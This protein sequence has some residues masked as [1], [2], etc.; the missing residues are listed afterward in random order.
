MAETL[1]AFLANR[2]AKQPEYIATEALGYL[3]RSSSECRAALGVV[4]QLAV[5]TL[6]NEIRYRTQDGEG[7]SGR[8]DVI[9]Q[10]GSGAAVIVVEAKFWAGLTDAQP[11]AYFTRFPAMGGVL[12]FVA[13]AAREHLLWRELTSR[14]RRANMIL[15]TE[16]VP[17]VGIRIIPAGN[18]YLLQVTWAAL[19]ARLIAAAETINDVTT[20]SD[21]RQLQGLCAQMDSEA[22]LPIRGE[23][24]TDSLPRRVIEYGKIIDDLITL[25]ESK[26]LGIPKG[27]MSGS[28]GWYGKTLLAKGH[29]LF[30]SYSCWYWRKHGETPIWLELEPPINTATRQA[31]IT[32]SIPF[33]EAAS[34]G[35][36]LLV[37]IVLP[38]QVER[39]E[40]VRAAFNYLE[41]IINALPQ[42]T[43]VQQSLT[44]PPTAPVVT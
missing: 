28:N 41:R 23:E 9:G 2:L 35:G 40:V 20:T 17:Q 21:A 38:T 27:R 22:F 26:P 34:D 14:C 12:L 42:I 15:G 16:R 1:L 11:V 33:H 29:E 39:D 32:D 43:G 18:H 6:T 7:D 5:P 31:L 10:D 24:L 4:A 3:L 13:P 37:P 30:L 25:F 44:A 8:P 19:L 36:K